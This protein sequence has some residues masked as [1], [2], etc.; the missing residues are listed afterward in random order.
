MTSVY[1][2][3]RLAAAYASDRPPVHGQILQSARLSRPADRA[4]DVG[5][6]AGLSTAALT[7]LAW[8]LFWSSQQPCDDARVSSA[9]HS[10]SIGAGYA[11]RPQ[12]SSEHAATAKRQRRW[13]VPATASRLATAS[14][15]PAR[16]AASNTGR[17]GYLAKWARAGTNK[18][19]SRVPH[20]VARL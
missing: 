19:A 10:T 11:A 17:A 18:A 12:E 2:S 7:P 20:P 6:G 16:Q 15:P 13:Y 1:D 3:E 9:A 8:Q 5:C 4:L 14:G